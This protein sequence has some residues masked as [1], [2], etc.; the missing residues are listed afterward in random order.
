MDNMTSQKM[1]LSIMDFFS[2][3]DHL[4]KTTDLVTCIEEIRNGKLHFLCSG[5]NRSWLTFIGY[6]TFFLFYIKKQIYLSSSLSCW[7]Y[8]SE[9]EP[10]LQK[11]FIE[12]V[13]WMCTVGKV[14]LETS[15]NWQENTCVRVSF[16]IKLQ[17][18]GL[19]L[20]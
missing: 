1:K 18:L 2:K 14:F 10:H 4:Q 7:F 13:V 6:I 19:Q 8:F 12:A 9:D 3:C 16:L 15:Q 17:V 5:R 11:I 20:Y